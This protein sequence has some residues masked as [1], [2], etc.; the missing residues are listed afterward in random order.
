M[1]DHLHFEI[2]SIKLWNSHNKELLP[3]TV[4]KVT[5]PPDAPF[6]FVAYVY[7]C[8]LNEDIDPARRNS[9]T[10]CAALRATHGRRWP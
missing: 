1:P 3:I 7:T 2:V 10:F 5:G 8:H 4:T 9:R 6:P